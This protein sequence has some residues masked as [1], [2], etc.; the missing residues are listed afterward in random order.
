LEDDDESPKTKAGA[1]RRTKAAQV[2]DDVDQSVR[3]PKAY[4]AVRNVAQQMI[5]NP[6]TMK[7][8]ELFNPKD[9]SPLSKPNC[10]D[11]NCILRRACAAVTGYRATVD[12]PPGDMPQGQ[13]TI[14]IMIARLATV[15]DA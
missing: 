10:L 8:R 12:C 7:P 6:L 4:M 14:A 2:P 13:I 15:E 5:N 3:G 1:R 9:L 11:H